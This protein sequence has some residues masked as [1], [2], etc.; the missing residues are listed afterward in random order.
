MHV[1]QDQRK[2]N[3]K[4][5]TRQERNTAAGKPGR[6]RFKTQEGNK[7]RA[8]PDTAPRKS[9]RRNTGNI[10]KRETGRKKPAATPK[11]FHKS[12]ARPFS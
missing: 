3:I 4:R 6:L 11:P 8:H 1:R 12:T 7:E 9:A 10:R 2:R 5:N